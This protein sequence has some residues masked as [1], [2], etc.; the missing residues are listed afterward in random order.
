VATWLAARA[1][2]RRGLNRLLTV[3]LAPGRASAS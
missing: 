1:W 3:G 2:D